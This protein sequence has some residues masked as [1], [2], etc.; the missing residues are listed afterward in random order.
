[1]HTLLMTNRDAAPN[2]EA[3][4]ASLPYG[5]LY[6]RCTQTGGRKLTKA[7]WKAWAKACKA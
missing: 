7:G 2:F 1:M 6:T 4:L 5:K 3:F